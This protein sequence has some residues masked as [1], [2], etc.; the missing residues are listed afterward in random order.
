MD[1]NNLFEVVWESYPGQ[2]TPEK[3]KNNEISKAQ[4]R[5]YG[6]ISK[7]SFKKVKIQN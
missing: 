4:E 7:H 2:N 1:P 5:Y 3:F 6:A